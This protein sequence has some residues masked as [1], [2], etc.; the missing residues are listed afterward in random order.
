MPRIGRILTLLAALARIVQVPMVCLYERANVQ[1]KPGAQEAVS[2]SDASSAGA[3]HAIMSGG[4]LAVRMKNGRLQNVP[5]KVQLGEVEALR[6]FSVTGVIGEHDG[7]SWWLREDQLK[8]AST[9]ES[10]EFAQGLKR[11]WS[12]VHPHPH[13]HPHPLPHPHPINR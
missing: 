2:R 12:K 6:F 11:S 9:S 5:A 4:S 8:P 13:L 3:I 10:Y 1:L 7:G